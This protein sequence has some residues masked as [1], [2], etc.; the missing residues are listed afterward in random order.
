MKINYKGDKVFPLMF[1]IIGITLFICAILL[2]A[3]FDS[4]AII[5]I[6][7]LFIGLIIVFTRKGM[8]LDF[9]K[10][11]IKR[12]FGVF[13]FKIG[14]WKTI[15]DYSSITVLHVNEQ[16][17]GYSRTGVQFGERLKTYR[18]CLLNENHRNR[19]TITDYKE[20]SIALSE[21]RII[22]EK[23]NLELVSFNPK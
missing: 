12:Y 9:K 20:E 18:I 6:L 21:A 16:S 17:Y 11:K 23:L 3:T 2:I 7:L 19:L 14:I 22:A 8:I 13:F 4:R 1:I 5:G 10:R 15:S